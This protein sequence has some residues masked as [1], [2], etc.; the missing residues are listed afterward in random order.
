MYSH[1]LVSTALAKRKVCIKRFNVWHM[2]NKP[3]TH[4]TIISIFFFSSYF[5]FHAV[6]DSQVYFKSQYRKDLLLGVTVVDTQYMHIQ[7]HSFKSVFVD[8]PMD[9][10][11]SFYIYIY[12]CTGVYMSRN[13]QVFTSSRVKEEVY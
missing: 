9:I 11:L 6:K 10:F 3:K 1:I 5:E 8:T 12:S 2:K 4:L 7:C 13:L